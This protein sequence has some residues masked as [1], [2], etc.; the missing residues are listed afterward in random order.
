MTDLSKR[1]LIIGGNGFLGASIAQRLA[2][3]NITCYIMDVVSNSNLA[4]S[5]LN[6][7]KG[8]IC[9]KS[10]ILAAFEVSKPSIVICVCAYGMSVRFFM[11]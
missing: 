8:D 10:S 11:Y 9:E 6:Y 5:S 3:M 2:A 7:I 4:V 1:I